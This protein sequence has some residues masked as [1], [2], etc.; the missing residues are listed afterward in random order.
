[1]EDIGLKKE[2]M[3]RSEVRFFSIVDYELHLHLANKP[4]S[5]LTRI[6]VFIVVFL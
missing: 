1:M 5:Q 3:I 2:K 4:H 6:R